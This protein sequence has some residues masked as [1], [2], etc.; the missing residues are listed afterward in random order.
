MVASPLMTPEGGTNLILEFCGSVI[1]AALAQFYL[2]PKSWRE[3]GLRIA[4][5]V[6]VGVLF[7]WVPMRMIEFPEGWKGIVAA[8]CLAAFAAW[9]LAGAVVRLTENYNGKR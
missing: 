5:S 4:F 7:S 3:F 9:W 8:S 6:P 1:G 2:P